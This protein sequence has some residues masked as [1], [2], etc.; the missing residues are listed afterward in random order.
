MTELSAQQIIDQLGLRPHPEGGFFAEICRSDEGL[1]AGGRRFALLG[2]SVAPGFENA[3][4]EAD[5]RAK[6]TRA[7]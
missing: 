3:D 7:F 2:Y 4:Y 5:D 1:P 6:F